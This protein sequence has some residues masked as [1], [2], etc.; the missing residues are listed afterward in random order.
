MSSVLSVENL[1]Y[2]NILKNINFNLKKGTINALIGPNGSG[3][4]T[5]LKSIFG[6]IC[7][8][9]LVS[10]NG[11]IIDEKNINELRKQMGIYL[12]I[13]VLENKSVFLNIMEPLK[14]LNYEEEVSKKKIYSISKKIGI[15]NLLY[16]NVSELSYSE[17][18][19]VAFTQSIIHEPSIILIDNIFDSLDTFYKEKILGYLNQI[20]KSKKCTILFV[21][22]N[23]E[24]IIFADNILIIKNEK[25]TATGTLEEIV[26]QENLFS[27]N[28]LKLPFIIDLSYK[29]KAYDLIDKLIYDIDEMVDELWQ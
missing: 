13:E 6:L 9:G 17:K 10:I 8:E 24:D 18:K 25:I 20:K 21:T 3:K 14:N 4:T 12:G 27:K 1:K 15:E 5:I 29:L 2:R 19:V 7:S 26:Q 23:N 22:N 11:S 28:D 16:K